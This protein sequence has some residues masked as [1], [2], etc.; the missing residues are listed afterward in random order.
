M[1]SQPKEKVHK[2]AQTTKSTASGE[3]RSGR[4]RTTSSKSTKKKTKV[5]LPQGVSDE[6]REIA[7]RLSSGL[8]HA[9]RQSRKLSRLV[10]RD[11]KK[12]TAWTI[13]ELLEETCRHRPRLRW[14]LEHCLE[15]K[16]VVVVR[17]A[18]YCDMCSERVWRD[19][20]M[21]SQPCRHCKQLLKELILWPG[22]FADAL[23]TG[24][25]RC[26]SMWSLLCNF[27]RLKRI[28]SL[29]YFAQYKGQHYIYTCD[30]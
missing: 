29:P 28:L 22:V 26:M 25:C 24:S 9:Y 23:L 15:R 12:D 8:V 1:T 14:E 10:G 19:D 27:C 17:Y 18:S 20:E 7:K 6:W 11:I 4:A 16:P 21:V 2:T 5:R 30:R 3:L 13:T